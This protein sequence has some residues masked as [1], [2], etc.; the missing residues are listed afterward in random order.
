MNA[1]SIINKRLVNAYKFKIINIHQGLMPYYRGLELMSGH[2]IIMSLNILELQYTL[3][4][5]KL[6]TEKSYYRLNQNLAKTIIPT[7]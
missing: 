6:M 1:T 3:L 4:M 5:K 2:F 7:L